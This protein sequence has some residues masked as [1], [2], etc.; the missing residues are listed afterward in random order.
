V[1]RAIERAL[2]CVD[3]VN[4]FDGGALF[5][6]RNETHRDV[7]TS[8]DQHSFLQ[9]DFPSHLCGEFIVARIDLTRF[10]RASEGAHHSTGGSGNHV[11]D[12]RGVRFFN[13]VGRDFVVLGDRAVDAE[14][15]WLRFAGKMRDSQRAGFAF[16]LYV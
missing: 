9:F 7:D 11:I 8:D 2:H 5:F 4:A 15:H 3:S 16:D 1:Q 13:F 10:Q 12:G 6:R 14:D